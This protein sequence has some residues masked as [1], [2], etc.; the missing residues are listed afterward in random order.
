[1]ALK[2]GLNNFKY[3]IV[4]LIAAFV[5]HDLGKL[6][7]AEN[8]VLTIIIGLLIAIFSVGRSENHFSTKYQNCSVNC[9]LG[10]YSINYVK[11]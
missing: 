4:L 5:T 7:Y 8:Y 3:R 10:D 2:F 1:M 6:K 9:I 11:N